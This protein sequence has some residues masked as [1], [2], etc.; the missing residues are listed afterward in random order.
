MVNRCVP[1]SGCTRRAPRQGL[2]V[3]LYTLLLTLLA[4]T[5]LDGAAPASSAIQAPP[6]RLFGT[7]TAT[8]GAVQVGTVVQARMGM[9]ICGTGAVG[10]R[11]SY[12]LD[13]Y[14]NPLLFCIDGAVLT[15][16]VGG[17]PARET[18]NAQPGAFVSLDLPVTAPIPP[19]SV[20]PTGMT[21]VL[22]LFPGCNNI[23]TTWPDST[24]TSAVAGAVS[25]AG[26]LLAIWRYDAAAGRFLGYAPQAVSVSDFPAVNRLEP[27]FIC[28]NTSGTLARPIAAA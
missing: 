25:P 12:Q 22:A 16:T 27:V 8:G 3:A 17:V 9:A 11:G 24:P 7:I 2:R 18:I 21:E 1:P 28:M 4:V 14:T 6:M 10:S 26:G 13:V 5:A 19:L 23:V 15:F 20:P